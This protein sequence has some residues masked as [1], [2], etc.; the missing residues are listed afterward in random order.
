MAGSSPSL[1][2]IGLLLRQQASLGEHPDSPAR[3]FFSPAHRQYYESPPSAEITKPHPPKD[4]RLVVH[5]SPMK[6]ALLWDLEQI[7][8]LTPRLRV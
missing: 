8:V 1:D 7:A 5:P 4:P 3:T 2:E 6:D